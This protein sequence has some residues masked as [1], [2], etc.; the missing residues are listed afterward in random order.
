MG[1]LVPNSLATQK[2]LDSET[3]NPIFQRFTPD[4][5]KQR[6]VAAAELYSVGYYYTIIAAV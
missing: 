4:N 2:W 3:G 1:S 5:I 6:I